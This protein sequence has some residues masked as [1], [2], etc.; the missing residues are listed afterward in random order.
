M[1]YKRLLQQPGSLGAALLLGDVVFFGFTDPTRAPST[2][3]IIA[4]LLLSASLYMAVQ[5]VC[6]LLGWYGSPVKHRHRMGMIVAGGVSGLF[7]LQ[8]IGQLSLRD[9][10]VLVPLVALAHFYISYNRRALET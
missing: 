5:G 6:A 2:F 8:S 4:F 7:A 10:A 3:F 1:N 9:F